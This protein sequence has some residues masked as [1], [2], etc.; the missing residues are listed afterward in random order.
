LFVT[1][2]IGYI[3]LLRVAACCAI[4]SGAIYIPELETKGSIDTPFP[5]ILLSLHALR[6]VGNW[7]FVLLVKVEMSYERR[8]CFNC[9]AIVLS[10]ELWPYCVIVDSMNENVN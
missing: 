10:H 1:D 2:G 9:Q 6:F 8:N 7:D 3:C 5:F 4:Y